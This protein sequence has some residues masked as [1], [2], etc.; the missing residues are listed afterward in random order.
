MTRIAN[1]CNLLNQT[2]QNVEDDKLSRTLENDDQHIENSDEAFILLPKKLYR[3]LNRR[4]YANQQIYS[5]Q[6]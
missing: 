6:L 3:N 4:T 1:N 2:I 5:C